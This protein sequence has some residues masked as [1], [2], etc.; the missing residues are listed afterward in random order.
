[1]RYRQAVTNF[2][3]KIRIGIRRQANQAGHAPAFSGAAFAEFLS[4]TDF[5]K[6]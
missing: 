3:R 4:I 2:R 1:M 6:G 5:S